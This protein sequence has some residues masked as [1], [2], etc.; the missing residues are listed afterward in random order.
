MSENKLKESPY[1]THIC[2]NK[3]EKRMRENRDKEEN[4]EIILLTHFNV[5]KRI[6][7]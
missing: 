2:D 1:P 6:E 3:S 7:L 4:E 5:I